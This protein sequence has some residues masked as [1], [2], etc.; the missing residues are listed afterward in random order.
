[1]SIGGFQVSFLKLIISKVLK[2]R[3]AALIVNLIVIGF[4]SYLLSFR[5]GILRV[6]LCLIIS[7]T[8][9]KIIK[10]KYDILSLSAILTIF[11]EP[12]CV[13]DFGF[14]LSYLCTFCV[15]WI[16]DMKFDNVLFE[17]LMINVTCVLISIPFVS[18]MEGCISLGTILFTI[19][20]NYMF[21]VAYI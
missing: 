16:Y 21:I 7:S 14:C 2:N 3:K 13:F 11:I 19:G 20:F 4:Y 5:S 6:L 8:C 1:M 18:K 17:M 12:T 15:M 9:K 10:N